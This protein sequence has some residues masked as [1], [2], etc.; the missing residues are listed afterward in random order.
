VLASLKAHLGKIPLEEIHELV[1][2]PALQRPQ[3]GG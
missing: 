1:S 3:Q 2:F